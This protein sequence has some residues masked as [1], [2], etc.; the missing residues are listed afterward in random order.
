MTTNHPR[1]VFRFCRLEI[2]TGA[3]R[4]LGG[5]PAGRGAEHDRNGFFA[6]RWLEINRRHY[7][8]AD[9]WPGFSWKAASGG[10]QYR[11]STIT[12]VGPTEFIWEPEP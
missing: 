9:P 4:G 2:S 8:R 1:D 3:D 5:C 11:K 12:I 6:R 10:D 7:C